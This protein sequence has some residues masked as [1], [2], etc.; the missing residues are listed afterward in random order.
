MLVVEA[1]DFVFIADGERVNDEIT[2]C[3]GRSLQIGCGYR[4]LIP[5]ES[6]TLTDVT[7]SVNL[8]LTKGDPV[9]LFSVRSYTLSESDSRGDRTYQCYAGVVY[10]VIVT[11]HF[12]DSKG[13]IFVYKC[14]FIIQCIYLTVR[15]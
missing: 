7:N 2:K 3:Q 1:T 12:V 6:I 4:E 15:V 5:A 13:I 8:P 9:G 14:T 11:I 10:N